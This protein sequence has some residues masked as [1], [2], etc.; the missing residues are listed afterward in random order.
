MNTCI[1]D[2]TVFLY[3]KSVISAGLKHRFIYY[4][5]PIE[6]DKQRGVKYRYSLKISLIEN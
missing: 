5:C 2:N 3:L 4:S 1:P 6:E